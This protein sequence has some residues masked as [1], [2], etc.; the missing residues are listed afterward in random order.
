VPTDS[1]KLL[2]IALAGNKKVVR[3]LTGKLGL[4]G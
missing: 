3:K 1:L 2:G 4:L